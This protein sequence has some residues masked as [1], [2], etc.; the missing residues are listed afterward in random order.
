M[1]KQLLA[2]VI[3]GCLAVGY[4]VA[5]DDWEKRKEKTEKIKG[6]YKDRDRDEDARDRREDE[7]E[8]Q[9]DEEEDARDR[10]EDERERRREQEEE[11][12]ERWEDEQERRREAE[13]EAR[14]RFEDEREGKKEKKHKHSSKGKKPKGV[15]G[16]DWG[17]AQ[18]EK[19]GWDEGKP[20]DGEKLGGDHEH[21]HAHTRP[22]D[23]DAPEHSDAEPEVVEAQDP[24]QTLRDMAK[25]AAARKAGAEKGS[26]T[27]ALIHMGT[28]K[29]LDRAKGGSA[30]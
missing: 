13:E 23:G 24:E 30:Q 26:A 22:R 16:R 7:R 27:E 6:K 21:D 28:D 4:A 9:R 1:F 25:D 14:E 11:A 20:G 18:G 5:D 2:L 12:R 15:H 17:A 3:A 8:R 10:W 29:V 19:R